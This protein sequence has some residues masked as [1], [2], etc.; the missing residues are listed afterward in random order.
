MCSLPTLI[1]FS[2]FFTSGFQPSNGTPPF[3]PTLRFASHWAELM[4]P[5]RAFTVVSIQF[6]TSTP[7]QLNN[8]T[9]A[10]HNKPLKLV[11]LVVKADG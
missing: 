4:R 1:L 10:G 8:S 2:S 9:P 3:S 6:N 5:F 11:Q 7:Q